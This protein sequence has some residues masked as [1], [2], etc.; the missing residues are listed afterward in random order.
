MTVSATLQDRVSLPEQTKNVSRSDY[1]R[2]A[3]LPLKHGNHML[4]GRQDGQHRWELK[5]NKD[6]VRIFDF[7]TMSADRSTFTV[8][9]AVTGRAFVLTGSDPS[10][11]VDALYK[12]RR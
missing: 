10:V 5:E 12:Y 9:Q 6:T 2:V 4:M 1:W 11:L 3:V 8:T 7:D